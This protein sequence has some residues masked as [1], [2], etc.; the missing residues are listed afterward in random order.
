MRTLTHCCKQRDFNVNVCEMCVKCVTLTSQLAVYLIFP[1]NQVVN[2]F[3]NLADS[4]H[5]RLTGKRLT[6]GIFSIY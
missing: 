6:I 1:T 3:L 5:R 4:T 2:V